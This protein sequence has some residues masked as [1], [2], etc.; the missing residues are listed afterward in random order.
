MMNHDVLLN[1]KYIGLSTDLGNPDLF[2]AKL[3]DA[4]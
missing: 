3:W 2:E 1:N 4:Q